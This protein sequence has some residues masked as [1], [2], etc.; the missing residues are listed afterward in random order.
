MG[1]YFNNQ[2]PRRDRERGESAGASKPRTPPYSLEAERSILGAILLNNVILDRV[3]ESG[4]EARD[5]YK[6]AHVRIFEAMFALYERKDVID[7]IT[8][9]ATLRDRGH[10]DAMG[11]TATLTQLLEDHFSMANAVPY[12]KIVHEKA[13]L[14]RMIDTCT[15]I[16]SEAM[17]GVDVLESFMD[18]VETK[19]LSVADSTT[20]KSFI[21][22]K[23][24]ILANVMNIEQLAL[25]KK[26]II[27]LATGFT[28]F[29]KLTTG[30]QP[31]QIMIVAARPGMGKTSWLT[32]MI[33][34][35]A[36]K[37][38][39]VVAFFSL[40]MTAHELGYRFLSGLSRLDSKNLKIGRLTDRDWRKLTDTADQLAGARILMDDSG[41]L[42]VVDIRS[43]CRRMLASEKKIDLIVIDYLQLMRGSKTA[44]RNDA[45]REREISEISRGLKELAK[46]LK[47]PIIA[48]S[49][50][51]RAVE[52]RVD[53]RPGL[54]DL[55]ESGSIEQD[56]DM[57][58]FIYRDEYYNKESEDRGIAEFI[59]AKNR[60]GPTET[61]RLAWLGQYTTF[62][63]LA[64]SSES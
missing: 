3:L 52:S 28:A 36:I 57:V 53:K 38:K 40:E 15:G 47:V 48:L 4:L 26:D 13:I 46:E 62:E 12:A 7:M 43:R 63:N 56:A 10:F 49:Q 31:G 1:E 22:M 25:N 50:L 45:N 30:L 37:E 59:V 58:C 55:R 34:H 42:S 41:G 20:T 16:V 19:I 51:S 44:A 18:E 29:D 60:A 61:I 27:G 23:S 8:M 35:V 14:R 6:E 2:E 9:T 32:S 24:V 33:S 54:S 39:A 11:G 5:F 21:D 17:E 64:E